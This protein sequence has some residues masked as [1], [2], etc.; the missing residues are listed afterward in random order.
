MRQEIA[1]ILLSG[2]GLALSGQSFAPTGSMH[3]ARLGHTA[4]LLNNGTVLVAGGTTSTGQPTSTAEIFD[5]QTGT[6]HYT[7][8]G[9]Q[10]TMTIARTSHTATKLSDG[11]VLLASGYAYSQPN[12]GV[13]G[14]TPI[15]TSTAELFDPAT[16]TF[17]STGSLSTPHTGAQALLLNDGRVMVVG[18][19]YLV[20]VPSG[21]IP[22]EIYNPNSGAWSADVPSLPTGAILQVAALLD[23]GDVLV[24]D[25]YDGELV[26]AAALYSPGTH[27]LRTMTDLL[28]TR[29]GA[30]TA[31][32]P[33]GQVLILGGFD[34]S[35]TLSS[36]EL[37]TASVAPSGQSQ[38]ALP[39][40][41][42]RRSPTATPLPNGDVLAAG[43]QQQNVI[44]SSAELRDHVTGAWRRAGTMST[45]RVVHTAT[46]LASGSVLIAG[47]LDSNFNPLQNAEIWTAGVRASALIANPPSLSF[48]YQQNP[49]GT[50]PPKSVS[51]STSGGIIP[52]ATSVSTSPP[53]ANWLSITSGSPTA[54]GTLTIGVKPD[55]AVGTYTGAVEL[56]SSGVINNPLTIPVLLSVAPPTAA[57]GTITIESTVAGNAF[58]LN[59]PNLTYIAGNTPFQRSG[60]PAGAYKITWSLI[61]GGYQTP[62]S[63]TKTLAP[64]GSTIFFGSYGLPVSSS[65]ALT[66]PLI[67]KTAYN[68]GVNTIFDHS[69]G[70][71]GGPYTLYNADGTITDFANEIGTTAAPSIQGCYPQGK[72]LLFFANTAYRP[73]P[74]TICYDNHPG[75][76]Y[77]VDSGN[78]TPILSAIA[79]Q[80]FYPS[81]MIG[82]G[83]PSDFH[84]LGIKPTTPKIGDYVVY[85]LHLDTYKDSAP[86]GIPFPNPWCSNILTNLPIPSNS[87]VPAGCVIGRAGGWGVKDN[88]AS[89]SAFLVH[90]HFEVHRIVSADQ[91]P[92]TSVYPSSRF[93]CPPEVDPSGTL[94]CIPVDP[95]GWDGPP[96][97]DPYTALTRD[98]NGNG[99]QNVRLWDY[100][101]T[102]AAIAP[103]SVQSS[104]TTISLSGNGFVP[105]S[106]VVAVDGTTLSQC[107]H[108]SSLAAVTAATQCAVMSSI[109]SNGL[110]TITG[111]WFSKA[112]FYYLYIS[113]PDG[114]NSNWQKLA[115]SP[116]IGGNR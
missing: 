72:G 76:D 90:L 62:Q 71:K 48:G 4:T 77:H 81:K 83:N 89:P 88:V 43:G 66:F 14:T 82:L 21:A 3:E 65:V 12:S 84:V 75:I 63:E 100:S 34:N 20:G 19:R 44:L 5:P 26:S 91:I 10:I 57:T 35:S 85:Y 42:S 73:P 93:L 115:V 39:M 99:L 109:T 45:A 111:K 13:G 23:S 79:G 105:G 49:A 59:G 33:N 47:G 67:G 108:V 41:D 40:N 110:A 18:G 60:L 112:L 101:P 55:M 106:S 113:T 28:A 24:A 38:Y 1:I 25:G 31:V 15:P 54:P 22:S 64:G 102:T 116:A 7:G 98:K 70:P 30:A 87:Q 95:Y 61:L 51:I 94:A 68:A 2:C 17:T 86:E 32:L 6:W 92:S 46:L 16:E 53:G 58:Q 50:I 11:R 103:T 52:L 27:T 36:T 29:G 80:V 8:I 56:T 37:Y 96:N 104:V 97:A 9:R 69:M 78:Q 107:A 114:R 74:L